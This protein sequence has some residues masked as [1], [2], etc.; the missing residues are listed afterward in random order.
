[1][2][3]VFPTA[4]LRPYTYLGGELSNV[5][6]DRIA[7]SPSVEEHHE[8]INKMADELIMSIENEVATGVPLNRI[9]VGGFSMGG[10]MAMHIG[11]RY[12]PGLAGVFALSS[13]LNDK[14]SVYEHLKNS[15]K[16]MQF[17]PL[18][19][20]HGSRDTLVPPSWG[21][22]TH[23]RLC[24]LGVGAQ[25]HVVRNAFHELTGGELRQL[26]DWISTRVPPP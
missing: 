12:L 5:W 4:P 19:M 7:L 24:E 26:F 18:Y 13:F 22:D 16:G 2:R 8:T 9:V 14:S 21:K 11:Y 3:V 17:P 1:M 15:D 23:D 25:F 20:C 10:A 6:F